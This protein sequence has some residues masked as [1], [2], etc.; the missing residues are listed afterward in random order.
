MALLDNCLKSFLYDPAG[1][2]R[3]GAAADME[4]YSQAGQLTGDPSTL[5]ID[6]FWYMA[7]LDAAAAQ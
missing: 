2:G 5:N 6:D 1:G 4:W 7:P 3:K